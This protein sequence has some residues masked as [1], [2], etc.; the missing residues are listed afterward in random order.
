MGEPDEGHAVDVLSG[1]ELAALA[2]AD[3]LG[4]STP[5]GPDVVIDSRTVP[6][7]A[8]FVALAGER[9]D[10]H[11][12]AQQAVDG[13]AAALLVARRLDIDVP[14]LLVRDTTAGLSQLASS[15]VL[16]AKKAGLTSI[17]VTGSSGKTSTK[18]LLAR[19]LA[20]A[21]PTVAPPGSL[22]NEIGVPLTAARV[23]ANTR[24]LVS[25]LG[26]RGLGHVTWLT[27]IVHP[28]IALVLNVGVAHLGE[29]GGIET[30]ARAKG[31]LVEAVPADGWAILNADDERVTAMASRTSGRVGFFGS[32]DVD[33]ELVVTALDVRLDALSRPSFTLRIATAQGVD[34]HP[35]TLRLIGRHQVDNAAA[36][37]AAA[38]AAGVPAASV[39]AS[40]SAAEP[41]SS[42]RM[43]LSQRAD[44]V[45]VLNDAYNA[46]PDSMA[47]ALMTLAEL[48]RSQRA[49]HAD[50]RAV[51]IL[52]D[53]LELGP[54]SATLHRRIGERVV[55]DELI[56]VGEHAADLVAGARANGVPG[57]V[58]MKDEIASSLALRPGDV[59]LV[60]ASRG[61]GLETV[62]EQLSNGARA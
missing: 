28:D 22:N 12:Y 44:G 30:T 19:I 35:V 15:L 32:A 6:A 26:A 42:W 20:D 58:M 23:D 25:E 24:Y 37:A 48:R 27:S 60:K 8:L 57:R 46:N 18:D 14:Q 9:F 55:A 41:T 29:F 39:A 7:G 51:A 61:L 3:L 36:A 53:M 56:A 45:L 52:G 11:D 43:A 13:G 49:V 40:L 16:R 62:A 38:V 17:G 31:E 34:E 21:A 10:G 33:A 54:D 1:A 5:I 59:V 4:A 47:A 50:A 2:H